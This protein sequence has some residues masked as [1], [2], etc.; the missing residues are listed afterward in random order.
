MHYSLLINTAVVA[1][2]CTAWRQMH[3]YV[4]AERLQ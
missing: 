2:V 1:V 4:V 3:I